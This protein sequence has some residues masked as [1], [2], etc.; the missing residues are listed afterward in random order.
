ME[1]GTEF[2]AAWMPA[3]TGPAPPVALKQFTGRVAVWEKNVSVTN[4]LT[5][6]TDEPPVRSGK[7]R[8][9]KRRLAPPVVPGTAGVVQPA[10]GPPV[11]RSAQSSRLPRPSFAPGFAP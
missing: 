10:H 5:T 11:V 6:Q 3:G 7:S 9:E 1:L 2:T 4:V 8:L